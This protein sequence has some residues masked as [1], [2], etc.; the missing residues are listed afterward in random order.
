MTADPYRF[1][2][3]ISLL[4]SKPGIYQFF[5][6][7][8]T[9]LYVGKAKN[10]RKRV[11]SYFAKHQSGKT[12]LLLR[13]TDDIR[14]IVVENESD[15]LLL[16]NNLIKKH[17]PR[18]NILLKDDKTFPWICIKK[19]PFPRI[20]STRN[21]IRDGSVYFGPYTSGLMVKTLL[22]LIRQIYKLRT[23]SLN[24]TR[25]NIDSEKFKVCL[26]Y[27]LGNC[28]A[29][30]IGHQSEQ[31]YS[32]NIQQIRE[33][34]KG[35]I[36]SV[37]DHLKE[38]MSSYSREMRFEEAQK[39][40]EKIDILSG[41][42]SRSAVVSNTIRNV[43]VFSYTRETDYAYVNYLKIV[44]GAVIQAFTVELKIRIDE[45]KESI[46]G[47]AIT[48]IRERLGSD[49]PEIIAPFSPDIQLDRIKYTIPK[50]GEKL[51]LVELSERNAIYYKL[52][53]KKKRA[54][55]KK[56]QERT[57]R[58]LEKLKNDL[59][60]SELPAHI[61]CFDNSNTMGT[62]PVAACVVF[63]NGKPSK[64]DYRH[65]N[66]KTVTGPDDFSSME[67][68]VYRRYKR[69][70][71][72]NNTLPQLVIIDGGKGQL[73]SAVK[74]IARLGLKEKLTVIGIAKKL[75]EIYF[76]GD[77]VPIYIDKNSISLK[78]IQQLRN[79]AHRFGITFHRNKRSSSMK[80]SGL[81]EIPGIGPK[82]KEILLKQ[83]GSVEKI[84]DVSPDLLKSIVGSSKTSLL[85]EYFQRNS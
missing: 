57:G 35:N 54:D 75:E 46:L 81:D 49:S 51:K 55:L 27:H 29:P 31:E 41:F 74:S 58:N 12:E 48:E 21:T 16:E 32:E 9:I 61:E 69:M 25:P 8:G 82:T 19:E 22:D 34:L 80:K 43:D 53:Q 3:T 44:N 11:A 56:P 2:N 23:C 65:F 78:I 62:N 17:Q 64:K 77:S 20:F 15:A 36:S 60:M 10:L 37:I 30:C 73:S 42:R 76:P 70:L 66:I 85:L 6:S 26:E 72:E 50:A 18:Y 67:E 33:I 47:Y 63:R 1:K 79:E 38:Q 24:L 45:E 5:D 28:K 52:G 84:K 59:H 4:P 83:F 71:N 68:I 40:K 39:I 7:S 14:H 13:R